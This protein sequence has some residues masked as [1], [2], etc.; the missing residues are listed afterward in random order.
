[1]A[2]W[3]TMTYGVHGNQI[4][5]ASEISGKRTT[6]SNYRPLFTKFRNETKRNK[7]EKL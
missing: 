3:F 7:V 6:G 5:W 2:A 4:V 1:M